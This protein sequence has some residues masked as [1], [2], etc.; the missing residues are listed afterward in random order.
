MRV[1]AKK[2][3][4]EKNKN[5][6]EVFATCAFFCVLSFSTFFVSACISFAI[7]TISATLLP[8]P[9]PPPPPP[10]MPRAR[11]LLNVECSSV[12]CAARETTSL[13]MRDVAWHITVTKQQTHGHLGDKK[14][15]KRR[16]R[17]S[18][19]EAAPL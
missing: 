3:K 11:A 15:T 4:G 8:P 12:A 10:L 6:N 7:S 2:K 17:L 14:Q 13:R 18:S 5:N 16:E 1:H 9:P 19:F